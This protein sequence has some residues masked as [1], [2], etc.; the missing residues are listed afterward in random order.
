MVARVTL[1]NMRQARDESVRAYGARLRGQASFCKFTQQ[2]TGWEATVDYTEAIL[3]DVLCQGL[4]DT[5]IQFYLLGDK[6]QDITMEQVL[7]FVE[8]K[9]AGKRSASRLL[10]H[11]AAD[12][13]S[14]SSY[15]KHKRPPPKK[16]ETCTY[17]GTKGHRSSPSTR[18][19]RT[20]CPAFNTVCNHCTRNITSREYAE[21]RTVP[22]RQEPQN[23]KMLSPTHCA[24]SKRQTT[25]GLTR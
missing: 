1:H 9:E 15:K 3:K 24:A 6:N 21:P 10:L 4:G 14:G 13:L 18:I 17:C 7:R 11:Q 16:Q 5:E 23:G 25:Q 22:S 8:A 19:R 2:C 20:E 12:A